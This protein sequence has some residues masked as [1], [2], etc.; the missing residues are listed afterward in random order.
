MPYSGG[1]VRGRL[2][3][4]MVDTFE[5]IQ[6]VLFLR[7]QPLVDALKLWSQAF[8]E[9]PSAFQT[10][11]AGH[12]QCQGVVRGT[13]NT[14]VVQPARIDLL[15]QPEPIVSD[16]TVLPLSLPDPAISS[17]DGIERLR[18]AAAG[19][20]ISRVACV[21]QG[22]SRA[23]DK[24]SAIKQ[25]GEVIRNLSLPR[26]ASDLTYQITVPKM[27]SLNEARRIQRLARWQTVQLVH[28]NQTATMGLQSIGAFQSIFGLH[29][30]VDVF[31]ENQEE[32]NS[33]TVVPVLEEVV[34]EASA[35]MTRGYDALQ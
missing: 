26:G 11:T 19:L 28:I 15:I 18:R 2:A 22:S 8:D 3:T 31:V 30:Y 29:T 10:L 9:P 6:I 4:F 24:A 5:Q 14:L 21:M 17:A 33:L 7:Q 34:A 16:T 20:L 27:S 32:L 25:A 1:L 13:L 23:G 12:T 35:I